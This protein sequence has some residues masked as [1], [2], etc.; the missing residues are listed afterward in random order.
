MHHWTCNR[1]LLHCCMQCWLQ[2]QQQISSCL[3]L[4]KPVNKW[5]R[6]VCNGQLLYTLHCLFTVTMVCS[7]T[8]PT[9]SSHTFS[10]LYLHSLATLHTSNM[11]GSPTQTD[12]FFLTTTEAMVIYCSAG[13]VLLLLM[14]FIIVLSVVWH[15]RRKHKQDKIKT[16]KK[17]TIYTHQAFTM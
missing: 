9:S 6:C 15:V 5:S 17:L 7:L 12:N 11:I 13:I 14:I 2:R 4:S 10:S 1:H 3:C 16:S 8:E